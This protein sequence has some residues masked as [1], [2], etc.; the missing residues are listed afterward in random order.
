MH[1]KIHSPNGNG[2]LHIYRVCPDVFLLF[3]TL[4]CVCVCWPVLNLTLVDLPGITKLPVGDQPKD[5]EYQIRDMIMQYVCNENCLI[6]AVMPATSD[7][8]NSDALQ[9]AKN[10]DP[11][12][13][14]LVCVVRVRVDVI[15]IFFNSEHW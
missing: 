14:A 7:L 2:W 5:I 11:Q 4:V 10:V 3:Q 1:L 12:G 8:T 6:L 9:L 13:E 15:V